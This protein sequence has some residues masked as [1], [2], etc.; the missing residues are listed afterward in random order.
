[1]V[2]WDSHPCLQPQPGPLHPSLP[3]CASRSFTA[4]LKVSM[5]SSALSG[6]A[7]THCCT[8]SR[9]E[10]G[11]VGGPWPVSDGKRSVRGVSA[12]EFP[13]A[14]VPQPLNPVPASTLTARF[15]RSCNVATAAEAVSLLAALRRPGEVSQPAMATI[16]KYEAQAM[17]PWKL[18][19]LS[20]W[21]TAEFQDTL[22]PTVM[23]KPTRPTTPTND[24]VLTLGM[25]PESLCSLRSSM[26]PLFFSTAAASPPMAE[27]SMA[28]EE[29]SDGLALEPGRSS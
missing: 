13:P 22:S 10:S 12:P 20:V 4:V 16:Q 18:L 27:G 26:E 17:P 23:P 19:W 21:L 14:I 7:W 1:M 15:V 6:I 28:D 3:L 2:H 24:A 11:V 9:A 25:K 5:P 29:G 8:I